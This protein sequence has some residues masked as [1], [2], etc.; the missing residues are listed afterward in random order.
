MGMPRRYFNYLPEFIPYH[1]ISTVGAYLLAVGFVIAAVY[2]IHSLLRGRAAPANP[3]GA[4]HWSGTA[5]RRRRTTTSRSRR[6]WGIP[7]TSPD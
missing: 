1:R 3:W 5:P 7:T 2:L 4:N 6:W